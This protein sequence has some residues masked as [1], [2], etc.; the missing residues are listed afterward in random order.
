MLKLDF[1]AGDIRTEGFK[2]VDVSD[3]SN[4]DY[5]WD[6]TNIP[7]PKEWEGA[8]EVRMDNIAEHIDPKTLIKV[9][10]EINRILIPGGKLW[11]RVPLLTCTP[12]GIYRAFTDPTHVNYF[13]MGTFDYW[14]DAVN[15]AGINRYR[16]FGKD[17]GIIPWKRIRNE[18]WG[19]NFLIVELIKV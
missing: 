13:T 2:A 14:D 12:D 10:N 5:V 1:G 18:E 15:A 16:Q 11:I 9:I 8:D 3:K 7:F 4:P 6:I 19:S 17:Y